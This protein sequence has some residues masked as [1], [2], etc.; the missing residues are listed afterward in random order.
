[1]TYSGFGRR[2]FQATALR[3][4][5]ILFLM[6][7]TVPFKAAALPPSASPPASAKLCPDAEQPAFLYTGTTYGY[8]RDADGPDSLAT[9]TE[10]T[11][12]DILTD[13]PQAILVGTGDNVAPEYGARYSNINPATPLPRIGL[14]SASQSR[15][16]QFFKSHDYVALVPGQF[17]FYFGAEFLRNAGRVLPLLGANLTIK[18]AKPPTPPQPLC[19]QPQLLLPT[20]VSLPLQ[21]GSASSGG[22]KGKSQGKG[23]GG[24][25]GQGSSSAA[26]QSGPGQ[27]GQLCL[28]TPSAGGGRTQG[29]LTLVAPTPDS[30]YP[31]T[32]ELEFSLSTTFQLTRVSLCWSE[33]G[34]SDFASTAG[35]A[36][37]P[38]YDNCTDLLPAGPP[39]SGTSGY[40]ARS[41]YRYGV[42]LAID[43]TT[44]PAKLLR[45][46]QNPP[47][48]DVRLFPGENLGLCVEGHQQLAQGSRICT[49][50]SVQEPFLEDVWVEVQKSATLKYAIF[51]VIDPQIQGL[52]SPENSS[53]GNGD[54][55]T[56]QINIQDAGPAL[57]QLIVT[58]RKLHANDANIYTYLLLAQMPPGTAQALSSTLRWNQDHPR[59]LGNAYTYRFDAIISQGVYDQATSD[60]TLIVDSEHSA[61]PIITPHPIVT[62]AVLRNPVSLLKINKS[63]SSQVTYVNITDYNPAQALR[64][65]YFASQSAFANGCGQTL[66]AVI[67]PLLDQAAQLRL[68]PPNSHGQCNATSAFQCLTL[69]TMTE[70]LDAD[71]AMLQRR[72]FY[73]QCNYKGT[74]SGAVS[75]EMIERVLWN[76]G[77]LTRVSVTGTTL[78]AILQS[79][80]NVAKAEQSWTNQPPIRNRDLVYIGITKSNGLYYINGAALEESKIY[81]IATSDQLA[82]GDSAYTQFAQVDLVTPTVFTGL[83]PQTVAI[84]QLATHAVLNSSLARLSRADIVASLPPMPVVS[85]PQNPAPSRE[86]LANVGSVE[87][88]QQN[89]HFWTI[90]LQQASFGYT[91]SK[92]N[93]TDASIS[94]NLAGVT[95]PNVAAPHSTSISYSD[96]L[97]I[98][99]QWTPRWNFGVDQ[100]LTFSRTSQGLLTT[101]VQ[102]TP[103][104]QVIPSQSTS[105]SANTLIASPFI[106]YQLRRNQ[107]HWKAVARPLTLTTDL[108]TTQQVYSTKTTGVAYQLNLKRQQ[109]WPQPSI[110]IRY[111]KDNLNFF[112]TGYLYQNARD[113][114]SALTVNGKTTQLTSG[115]TVAEITN[116]VPNSGDVAIPTYSTYQ[117][118]GAYWLG[119]YT[120]R[121]T[122][123]AKTIKITYQALTFGNFF[124]YGA[125]KQTS[126]ILT[127][128]AAE[129]SNNLQLQLWGNLSFGPG[130]N[131]FWFQDQGH[132]P[133]SSLTR[134]DWILQ[135]NYLFDW[136]QGLE[137]KDVLQGKTQ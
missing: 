103:S 43:H 72:D 69:R 118:Q 95:N 37:K 113:V 112:E 28:Q 40:T 109:N 94:T 131:I 82:L 92:P 14:S 91:S 77:Y 56:R 21:T 98:L 48:P 32:N 123:N 104:G 90:T 19:G 39:K 79:S 22:K 33:P 84:G 64:K 11:I 78:K 76:T 75:A 110:G 49:P 86:P 68:L 23:G 9:A 102:K 136:H 59:A 67:I 51:G 15:A 100:L 137:W 73:D 36:V 130:Y 99:Y 31:W 128:S 52:V 62:A 101:Q 13:C 122:G 133:G 71:A 7:M 120:Q 1:M 129:L 44:S 60:S 87:R 30:I 93:Q 126:S 105:L 70:T 89:R 83:K 119:M 27:S 26:G 3:L 81:S 2:Y 106:E 117:Q 4:F 10:K 55:Y 18:D 58:F 12:T 88:E 53:W 124:A 108:S 96:S 114:L 38:G 47:N 20:Q 132:I 97:R 65:S 135:L 116:I 42:N 6:A 115:T 127:R 29:D 17:D 74:S 34:S 57:D 46:T 5:L 111:E 54:S 41:V 61:T 107:P 24:G 45:L 134:R 121:L 66:A 16:V 63:I 25:P 80:D 125:A 8:L 50:I 35:P 85:S